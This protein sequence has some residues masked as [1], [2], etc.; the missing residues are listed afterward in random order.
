MMDQVVM[1]V[2]MA[3]FVFC[4]VMHFR[5]NDFSGS[6]PTPKREPSAAELLR[7]SRIELVRR[8]RQ[9]MDEWERAF[10]PVTYCQVYYQRD[11]RCRE[12][13]DKLPASHAEWVEIDTMYQ[14]YLRIR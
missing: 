7:A 14:E 12:G 2:G 8:E 4:M 6:N 3:A 9:A 11:F 13:M 1:V 5:V 10:G